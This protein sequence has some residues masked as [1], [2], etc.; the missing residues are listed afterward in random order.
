MPKSELAQ[1]A[2]IEI[3]KYHKYHR[4]WEKAI[5]QYHKAIDISPNSRAAHDAKTAEAAIY[6][7][8]QDFSTSLE[9]FQQVLSETK[10]WDQIKYCNYWI[11]E[12]KRKMSFPSEQT[13]SCGPESL[14][15][16][17]KMLRLDTKDIELTKLFS[18]QEK[19]EVSIS[20]LAK[21]AK[22]KG[23]TPTVVKVTRDQLQ[24]I[25]TPFIALVKPDHYV[26]VTSTGENIQYID[27]ADQKDHQTKNISEFGEEFKGYALVFMRD[28]RLAKLDSIPVSEQ[29]AVSAKGGVCWCCPPVNLGGPGYNANVEYVGSTTGC[30]G[31]PYWIVNTVSLNFIVQ[32]I[33]FRYV[34]RGMPIEFIRTYNGDDPREYVFGRSWT[35]NYNI[36]LVENPDKSIDVR[37]GDGKVDHFYWNGTRYQGP[38]T[39]YDIL[40]KKSD[41][42]YELKIKKDKTIQNFDT[43]GRLVNI[44]DRNGNTINF[45]YDAEGKLIKII[46]PNSKNI[47]LGYGVNKKISLLTLP[48]NRKI[49]F[50]YDANNN[51]VQSIDT[52][53]AASV[54]TYDSASY[55]TA[56][57]TPHQGETK[58]TYSS[59][60]EG[61]AIASITDSLNNKRLYSNNGSYYQ[62]AVKDNRDNTTLYNYDYEGY[63]AGITTPEGNKIIFKYNDLGD[64]YQIIDSGGNITELKYDSRGNVT[65]ITDALSNKAAFVYDDSDNLMQVTDA[66]S[67]SSFFA[68]NAKGNLTSVRDPD[69]Q[70]TSFVYNSFGQVTKITDAKNNITQF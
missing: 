58:I 50:V 26:V 29:E 4:D 56:I 20:E 69:D 42:A 54:I 43:Q 14:K 12:L 62:I 23:L 33:D 35:F 41:G 16:V 68:Y 37:R 44:K 5:A 48:D 24:N 65:L 49:R 13:F 2:Y 9:M 64:R 19:G 8:R 11:K 31:M 10:D 60:E 55:I 17:F 63:T 1:K 39:V 38:N 28:H 61:Y 47:T 52:K 66:K 51:L 7:F 25:D 6:Y 3:G 27:P 45:T 36:S 59:S 18:S 46:D 67:Q 21:A 32:D 34:A 22:Q 70:L 53:A 57:T 30:P 40:T 15:I